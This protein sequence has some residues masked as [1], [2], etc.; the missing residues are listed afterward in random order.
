[1]IDYTIWQ[2]EE[3][4]LNA[5]AH[6]KKPIDISKCFYKGLDEWALTA[7]DCSATQHIL[8]Q[9]NLMRMGLKILS[10]NYNPKITQ[11]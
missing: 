8:T 10:F 3:G 11:F 6:F 5:V 2:N 7:T 1:M 4:K 9:D